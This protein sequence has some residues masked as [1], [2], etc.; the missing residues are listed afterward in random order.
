L[1]HHIHH[2]IGDYFYTQQ[3]YETHYQA[4]FHRG[5]DNALKPHNLHEEIV[6]VSTTLTGTNKITL[7]FVCLEVALVIINSTQAIQV[8]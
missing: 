1:Q 4:K 5:S 3:E 2:N 6:K 7:V 8:V